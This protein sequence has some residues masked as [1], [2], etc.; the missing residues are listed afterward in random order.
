MLAKADLLF[1]SIT[2]NNK[3]G[4]FIRFCICVTR[5]KLPLSQI[6]MDHRPDMVTIRK[7]HT[8]TH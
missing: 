1:F 6:S 2:V 7:C 3:A 5:E 8:T 4:D